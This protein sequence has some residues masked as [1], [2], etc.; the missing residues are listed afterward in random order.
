MRLIDTN[1]QAEWKPIKGFEGLYKVS[2]NGDILSIKRKLILKPF[3][4]GKYGHAL[5]G[6]SKNGKTV[7]RQV[8]RVVAEAFV[9]NTDNKPEVCHISNEFNEN[10]FLDNSASN[11]CWG[12]HLENCAFENTRKRQSENHADVSGKKNPNYGNNWTDEM[13]RSQTINKGKQVIQWFGNRIIAVYDSI[14]QAGRATGIS[15]MN[16]K[17]VCDKKYKHAGGYEWTYV[18]KPYDVDKV[19]DNLDDAYNK[20]ELG[21]YHRIVREGGVE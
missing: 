9:A 3:G 2:N 14:K 1:R 11:L 20:R 6:L 8:H 19:L 21:D 16:I 18:F 12:T 4:K 7:K 15:W 13:K 5:V 10:G 17:N